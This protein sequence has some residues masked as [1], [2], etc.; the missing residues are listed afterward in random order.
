MSQ[1][2]TIEVTKIRDIA[3]QVS[4]DQVVSND[5]AADACDSIRTIFKEASKFGLTSAGV[6]RAVFR[7]ALE[8]RTNGCNCPTCRSSNSRLDL[9]ESLPK[10][11]GANQSPAA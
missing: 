11:E 3:S 2:G 10:D 8:G 6:A 5:A 1:A 4:R 9:L 7:P